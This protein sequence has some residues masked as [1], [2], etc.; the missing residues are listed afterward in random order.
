MY[1]S[2]NNF[3]TKKNL[4]SL[5]LVPLGFA[6]WGSAQATTYYVRT[7]G[8]DAS[9]CTGRGDL[10]Y[11]GSGSGQACAWKHPY[12]ALAPGGTKRIAGGDT[13]LIGSGNYMMGQGAPGAGSCAASSC[14]M[15]PIPSGLSVTAK[16][17]ILGKPGAAA[18]RLWGTGGVSRVLNLDGSSNVE[19]GHLD[20]TDQSDCVSGHS[21]TSAACAA[22]DA[23]ANRGLY[24]RDSGNVWLHDLN[25][26]GMAHTGINAGRLIHH[27]SHDESK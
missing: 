3:L 17:R 7:D 23:Y 8:G 18:P 13:L 15:S 24:A 14:Y 5:L 19:I 26:H 20:I 4:L 25:I 11:S 10:A 16:T 9:Q 12:F 2:R 6:A 21:N 27:N 1:V 22:G